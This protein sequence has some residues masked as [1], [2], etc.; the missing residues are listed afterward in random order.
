MI[1]VEDLT[2]RK[3]E[4]IQIKKCTAHQT[5]TQMGYNHIR[6]HQVQ[7]PLAKNKNLRLSWAK[8]DKY[9]VKKTR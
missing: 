9:R 5:L 2:V 7:I 1:S 6:S 3:C 4:I 8:F